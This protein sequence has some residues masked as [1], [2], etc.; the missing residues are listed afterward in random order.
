MV[1]Q[2]ER[3]YY[4]KNDAYDVQSVAT[5]EF[6]H[7]LSLGHST[8]TQAVMYPN[9]GAGVL[10]RQLYSDDIDGIKFI[11]DVAQ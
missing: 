4:R 9:I 8:F 2:Y 1:L 11:Y 6:G 5:H 10:K 3:V 7:W